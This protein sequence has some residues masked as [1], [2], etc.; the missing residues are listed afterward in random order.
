MMEPAG[1]GQTA[2]RAFLRVGGATLAR[3]QLGIAV[4]LECQRVICIAREVVP[5]L[6]ALQ[7]EA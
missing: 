7:H 3:H 2:P 1:A 6:I 5:E 4:A